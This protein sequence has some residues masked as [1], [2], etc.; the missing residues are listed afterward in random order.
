ML[1]FDEKGLLFPHEIIEI[2]LDYFEERFV[3]EL[4]DH[5]HRK[6]I[7]QGYQRYLDALKKI[8]T[9]GFIQFLNGSFTHSKNKTKRS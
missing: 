5:L 7:F 6:E 2:S 1:T 3:N 8:T 9:K 4:E